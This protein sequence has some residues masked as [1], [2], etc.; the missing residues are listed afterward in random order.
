MNIHLCTR[1]HFTQLGFQF[2]FD[3]PDSTDSGV[4]IGDSDKVY[5]DRQFFIQL[6]LDFTN[7]KFNLYV[8]KVL[9]GVASISAIGL[10]EGTYDINIGHSATDK[11]FTSGTIDEVSIHNTIFTSDEKSQWYDNQ[12]G[13]LSVMGNR[14]FRRRIQ[15]E[16]KEKLVTNNQ[17]TYLIAHGII[18]TNSVN[19]ELLGIG[20]GT[21]QEF[22][23][24]ARFGGITPKTIKFHL[25]NEQ[26]D[27]ILLS[28]D[29]NGDVVHNS[30]SAVIDY[31]TGDISFNTNKI[32]YYN[33]TV[34]LPPD[35]DGNSS[36]SLNSSISPQEFNIYYSYGD[37][38][39]SASSNED[40]EIIPKEEGNPLN[41]GTVNYNTGEITLSFGSNPV[42]DN[43]HINYQVD[44]STFIP[45]GKEVTY[46][47]KIEGGM[48]IT[49]VG[50]ENKDKILQ[51]YSTFPP[52]N[53]ESSINHISPSFIID[54]HEHEDNTIYTSD[55]DGIV[56]SDG[57]PIIT[58]RV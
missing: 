51:V 31:E 20:S 22:N 56:T 1:L 24:I 21:Y 39:Y 38:G 58:S 50:I 25:F 8:N 18:D 17:K 41:L 43:F 32:L 46:E 36:Y 10:I 12:V 5:Y 34:S 54:N 40:G 9:S 49:E 47:Y 35:E 29:G 27:P 48:D 42:D 13:D 4:Q 57:M 44:T 15:P 55:L 33:I 23:I 53:S 52:I 19:D 7:N 37:I 45:E 3:G 14:V 26:G 11:I 16:E 6:E 2:Y 30:Y 28:D